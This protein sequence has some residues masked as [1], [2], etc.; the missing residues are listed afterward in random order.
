MGPGPWGRARAM[1]HTHLG[2]NIF[3][4][5]YPENTNIAYIIEGWFFDMFPKQMRAEKWYNLTAVSR[6]DL[7][8]ETDSGPKTKT[9]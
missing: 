8:Y 5:Q 2:K 6:R 9:D 7:S 4:K 1:A 3:Q